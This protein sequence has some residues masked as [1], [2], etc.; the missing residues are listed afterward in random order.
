MKNF[1]GKNSSIGLNKDLTAIVKITV[2]TRLH[3]AAI[4]I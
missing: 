4:S 3:N 2:E 1:N